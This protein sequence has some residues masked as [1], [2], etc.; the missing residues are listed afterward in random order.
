MRGAVV[1]VRVLVSLVAVV[2]IAGCAF[3][4][5]ATASPTPVPIVDV[6]PTAF[7]AQTAE[8]SL[9]PVPTATTVA[10]IETTF[11]DFVPPSPLCPA[12]L[13]AVDPPVVNVRAGD[14]AWHVTVPEPAT[15]T[16]CSSARSD[17]RPAAEPS[18]FLLLDKGSRL[19]FGLE[20][21]WRILAW[22]GYDHP[23]DGEG[24]NVWPGGTTPDMPTS[25]ELPIA[26]TRDVIVG[27]EIWC[28]SADSRVIAHVGGVAWVRPG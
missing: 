10:P 22:T 24:A 6:S 27:V 4:T 1:A 14:G 3:G 9:T 8:P 23:K 16:T 20:P 2:S 21:A 15:V 19:T 28:I 5:V 26:P 17:D 25:I 13:V 18:E 12:P 11:E 7:A